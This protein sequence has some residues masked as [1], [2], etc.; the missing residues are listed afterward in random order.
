MILPSLAKK[1]W[2]KAGNFRKSKKEVMGY[3][4][5]QRSC[6]RWER[7][8]V[9]SDHFVRC[10]LESWRGGMCTDVVAGVRGTM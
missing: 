1:N 5:R 4:C 3:V 7:W 2:K 6:M 9:R 10:F 8:D